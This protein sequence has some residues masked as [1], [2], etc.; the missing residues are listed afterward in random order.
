MANIRVLP[1]EDA[2]MG[3]IF[4]IT[5][6]AFARNEPVRR[7]I[8]GDFAA[9]QPSLGLITMLASHSVLFALPLRNC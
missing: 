6:L 7:W 3:R 4:E 1:A 5:A 2:D 9:L 8:E